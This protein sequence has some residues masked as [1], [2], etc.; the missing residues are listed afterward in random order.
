MFRGVYSL[1]AIKGG[2][3]DKKTI[4]INYKSGIMVIKY[5]KLPLSTA[6]TV[7]CYTV[8]IIAI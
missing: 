5:N 2:G 6:G 8:S 1:K 3:K 4:I 7:F